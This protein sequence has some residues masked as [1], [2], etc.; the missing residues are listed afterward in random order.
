MPTGNSER[1]ITAA[2]EP[3]VD[4]SRR[5]FVLVRK[6]KLEEDVRC[7][8]AKIATSARRRNNRPT[9]AAAHEYQ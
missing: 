4:D 8:V 6:R 3:G 1:H 5:G 2:I 7:F 9:A